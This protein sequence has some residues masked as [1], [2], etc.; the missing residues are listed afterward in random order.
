LHNCAN[1]FADKVTNTDENITSLVEVTSRSLG[2]AHFP[3]S[4][5]A[6]PIW[7]SHRSCL[8]GE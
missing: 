5:W 7:L 3:D 8:D 2:R 4:G 1:K 6:V